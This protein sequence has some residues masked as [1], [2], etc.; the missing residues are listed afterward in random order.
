MSYKVFGG[1]HD[2]LTSIS[3][4]KS[5]PAGQREKGQMVAVRDGDY[6]VYIW[7]PV[8]TAKIL[9]CGLVDEVPGN[10][11]WPSKA[12][13]WYPVTSPGAFVERDH[14]VEEDGVRPDLGGGWLREDFDY[15]FVVPDDISSQ[16]DGNGALVDYT[17]IGGRWV[18]INYASLIDNIPWAKRPGHILPRYND[19]FDIGS[20]N[21]KVRDV[22]IGGNSIWVGDQHRVSINSGGTLKFQKRKTG[23]IPEHLDAHAS[24]AQA[25]KAMIPSSELDGVSITVSTLMPA[26][27]SLSLGDWEKVAALHGFPTPEPGALFGDSDFEEAVNLEGSGGVSNTAIDTRLTDVESRFD[28]AGRILKDYVDTSIFDMP[29]YISKW[30][31]R[32][33]LE[34]D[35]IRGDFDSLFDTKFNTEDVVDTT[36]FGTLYDSRFGSDFDTRFGTKDVVLGT[37]DWTDMQSRFDGSGR[38]LAAN[39]HPDLVNSNIA[40][41]DLSGLIAADAALVTALNDKLDS[42]AFDTAAATWVTNNL[43][44]SAETNGQMQ[45]A[46]DGALIDSTNA[47]WLAANSVIAGIQTDIAGKQAAGTYLTSASSLAAGKLTGTVAEARVSSS[48][49]RSTEVATVASDVATISSRFD[50]SGNLEIDKL[51]FTI[52][53]NTGVIGDDY[54]PA[55]S[56]SKIS[57]LS[58]SL[59]GK[60]SSSSV[61]NIQ[62][63]LIDEGI[64][65]SVQIGLSSFYITPSLIISDKDL[66]TIIRIVP[67]DEIT[68]DYHLVGLTTFEYEWNQVAS[69]LFD[70]TGHVAEGFIA[71]Q[72]EELYPAPDPQ[73]PPTSAE[74]GHIWWHEFMTDDQKAAAIDVHNYYTFYNSDMLNAEINTAKNNTP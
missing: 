34:T 1:I 66:K 27:L 19:M 22:Y 60:A 24:T 23:K 25:K 64:L 9:L 45:L 59:A 53:G 8:A 37:S 30:N 63:G 42:S 69:D 7:D 43:E 17:G 39:A 13:V 18:V 74:D 31:E 32:L 35:I 20:A 3:A 36:E 12:N 5:I 51:P 50:G 11:S 14:M 33:A 48:I 72:L 21:N 52:F 2:I 26:G 56:Q 4:L 49:A 58:T 67:V 15:L 6:K 55:L 57:G 46:I 54:I 40:A 70:L 71:E 41:T 10:T 44:I 62:T 16:V 65:S 68:T 73:N 28:G 29:E 38:L 47:T 61:T